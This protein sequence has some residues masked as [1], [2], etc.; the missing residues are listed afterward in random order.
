MAAYLNYAADLL[1]IP[2]RNARSKST[3]E[4]LESFIIDNNPTNG[5]ECNGKYIPEEI[6]IEIFTNLS[7][8]DI[9][10]CSL[11]CKN[12]H[13][14]AKSNLLWQEIYNKLEYPKKAKHLP[15]YVFYCYFST[16]NFKNLIKNG[17]GEE[18][19]NYWTIATNG[20]DKFKVE[21]V[22]HG[23]PELPAGIPEFHGHT[24]C[25]AT[26]FDLCSKYQVWYNNFTFSLYQRI[27]YCFTG[28]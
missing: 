26:S 13:N 23:A 20:G 22:P 14:I 17:N 10:K 12:W 18:N 28:D 8:S 25:F 21:R 4:F 16:E 6:W 11:V 27:T 7:P 15:W 9:L 2:T 24:S 5:L 1:G 19:F 3:M